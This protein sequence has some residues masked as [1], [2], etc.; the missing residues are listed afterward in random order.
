MIEGRL[1]EIT[2]EL[3]RVALMYSMVDSYS[4]MGQIQQDV[5]ILDYR[6]N[7]NGCDLCRYRVSKKE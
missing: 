5:S 4:D 1:P 6:N 7:D 3:Y 2:K